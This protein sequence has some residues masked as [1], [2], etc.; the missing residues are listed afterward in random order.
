MKSFLHKDT[1]ASVGWHQVCGSVEVFLFLVHA[2]TRVL[3]AFNFWPG[4]NPFKG[5]K[6]MPAPCDADL[7]AEA[8]ER[9]G[10]MS[11][12]VASLVALPEVV[13]ASVRITEILPFLEARS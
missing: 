2:F 7:K 4:D 11:A 13:A 3:L 6:A 5:P 1:P 10:E 12:P 9:D 8:R